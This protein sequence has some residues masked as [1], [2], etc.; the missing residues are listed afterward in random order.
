MLK[1]ITGEEGRYSIF[2]RSFLRTIIEFWISFRSLHTEMML[3]ETNL[4]HTFYLEK[5]MGVPR[6]VSRP[7]QLPFV[8]QT[9]EKFNVSNTNSD[10]IPVRHRDGDAETIQYHKSYMSQGHGITSGDCGI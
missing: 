1:I 5:T 6:R 4:T 9:P 10:R 3:L 8:R 7:L 2:F